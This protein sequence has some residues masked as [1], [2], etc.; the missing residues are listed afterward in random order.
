M[1]TSQI[2]LGFVANAQLWIE[3]VLGATAIQLKATSGTIYIVEVDNTANASA[4]SF[5][6]LYDATSGTVTVGTTAPDWIIKC[7]GNTKQDYVVVGGAAFATA[8]TT[9][10]VTTGG[11]AGSTAPTGAVIVKISY[12]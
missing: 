8:L 1:A 5:V 12:V 4:A 9:A 6:K 10:C 11:T 2:G 7:A 3:T